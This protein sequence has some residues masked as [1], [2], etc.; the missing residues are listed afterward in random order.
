VIVTINGEDRDVRAGASVDELVAEL[1]S[2][3]RGIAVVVDGTVV[4]RSEW[5]SHTLTG[6][7]SVEVITAV[8]GG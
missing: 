3:P 1:T 4:P 6:R 8:Q 2:A 7:E 5:P